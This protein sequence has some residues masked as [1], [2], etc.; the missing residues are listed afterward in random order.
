MSRHIS[1][2]DYYKI[3]E[4]GGTLPVHG[5]SY[6][7]YYNAAV[8]AYVDTHGIESIKNIKFK[9]DFETMILNPLLNPV[10]IK[11]YVGNYNRWELYRSYGGYGSTRG[12]IIPNK[13]YLVD[14]IT[15]LRTPHSQ[16]LNLSG[17]EPTQEQRNNAANYIEKFLERLGERAFPEPIRRGGRRKTRKVKRSSRRR[18]TTKAN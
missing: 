8:L 1:E 7:P 5:H 11:L 12:P 13:E 16:I 14:F 4:Q 15:T 6:D 2:D 9:R 18:K 10:G 17:N 3:R